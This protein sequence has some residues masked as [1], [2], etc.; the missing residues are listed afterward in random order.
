VATCRITLTRKVH[1]REN[2]KGAKML[3]QCNK[4]INPEKEREGET[5]H[6]ILKFNSFL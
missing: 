1:K 4:D 5:E 2:T 6:G 3:A